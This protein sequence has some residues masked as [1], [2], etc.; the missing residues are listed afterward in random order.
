MAPAQTL[1]P[2]LFP[3]EGGKVL[4]APQEEPEFINGHKEAAHSQAG[5][6]EGAEGLRLPRPWAGLASVGQTDRQTPFV[7]KPGQ[8]S[9]V[10]C[11]GDPGLPPLGTVPAREGQL[12][13]LLG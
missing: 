12:Q 8:L 3:E 10:L 7:W 6:G 1:F 11:P 5:Q 4:S 9:L 2:L 13:V